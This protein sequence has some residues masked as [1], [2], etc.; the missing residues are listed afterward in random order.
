MISD[1]PPDRELEWTDDGIQSSKN[2]INR[3]N[4]YFANN[5]STNITSEIEKMVE[6][7]ANEVEKNILNFS[8]NKCVASI[9]T[10]LNYFLKKIKYI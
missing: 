10:L 4:R 7:F 1:S 8:L 3:I 6:K 5:A 9:Y 2:L